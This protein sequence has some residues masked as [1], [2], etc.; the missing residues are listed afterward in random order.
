M[1][2]N[3]LF[4]GIAAGRIPAD[5]VFDDGELLAFRDIAPQAPVHVL[6]ITKQ[7]HPN[8]AAA[9]AADPALA[10]RMLAAAAQLAAEFA[11]ADSGFRLVVNTGAEAGQSVDHVHVHLLGK[12]QLGWPP[13]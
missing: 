12:R 3:C 9:A 13:G 6:I 10:G 8:I 11:V 5:V 1:S 4:C 2:D 7:H